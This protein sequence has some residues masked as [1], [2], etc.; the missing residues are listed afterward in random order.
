MNFDVDVFVSYAHLDDAALVEGQKGWVSNLHRA[1]EIRVAQFLG[2]PL[3]IWRDPKLHGDDVFAETLIERLKQALALVSVVSPRYVRSEWT[4][5]ELREFCRLADAQ[6]DLPLG[7]KSRIFKVLKTPVSLDLQSPELQDLIGYEFF[8]IDSQSGKVLEFEEVFGPDAQ[9]NFWIKLDDLAHDVCQL[10]GKVEGAEE[11]KPIRTDGGE[12]TIFLAETTGDLRE[13]REAIKRDLQEHGYRVL[14][15]SALSPDSAELE[16]AVRRDLGQSSMSIHLIGK[17]YGLI[18]EGAVASVSEIQNELAIERAKTGGFARL[19]WI[20]QGLQVEDSRQRQVIDRLRT[21]ARTGQNADLLESTLE[22]L[23]TVVQGALEKVKAR[24][25]AAAGSATAALSAGTAVATAYLLYDQRD[26][27]AVLPSADLL[28][29]EGL[30]VIHPVF[31]GDE[32][33]IREYHEENLR[34]ADA[35]VIFYGSA[36]EVWI[37]RKFREIQKIAGYGRTKPAPVVAVCTLPPKTPEKE[38]FRSHEC[39]VVPQ[40]DGLSRNAWQPIVARLK[41]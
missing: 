1:L 3:H 22:D 38:R 25:A 2:K 35:V 39:T 8:A 17:R 28:F 20:P 27:Y 12:G 26:G 7:H 29:N 37:R 5:R 40:G 18:P 19:I 6:Q 32:G 9:R 36:N 13:Q 15:E 23:R 16:V 21:D 14:P 11:V 4:R 34:T 41:G 24:K 33:E 31:E 30:E 10:I